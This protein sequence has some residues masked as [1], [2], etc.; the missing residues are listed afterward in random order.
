MRYPDFRLK[1]L[2]WQKNM[3]VEYARLKHEYGAAR[4]KV[5][6][7]EALASIEKGVRQLKSLPVDK[8][9]LAKE[10]NEYK[11]ILN[12]RPNGIRKIWSSIDRKV[13]K[14]RL[15]GAFLGRCA[16]CTLGTIVEFWEVDRM[17]R[18]AK[19]CGM[20]F[21]PKNYW[22]MA[23]DPFALRYGH[24]P[25][26][27]YTRDKM[28]GVPTD[29]DLVYTLLGLL[30]VEQYGHNF[31]VAQNGKAWLKYLPHACTAEK[32][33]LDNLKKGIAAE[34]VAD[35]DNPYCEWIGADIRSDPW[36][37]MAPGWPEMAASMAYRDAVLSHR[38]QGIYGEM[39]FSAAIS[40]AFAVSTPVEALRIGL[41]EIPKEC[42][43]SK[44]IKWALGVSHK[45]KNYKDARKAVDK[46]FEGMSGVHTNNNACLTVFGLTIGGTD[47]TRVISET[48]AMGLD[49]DCTAATAGSI[50]GAIVGKKNIP[51]HWIKRFNNKIH[52]YIIGHKVFAIDDV[53]GR[54]IRQAEFIYSS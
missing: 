9:L 2:D 43:L 10:P 31:T 36:A 39:F 32:V 3:L 37:Y 28:D 45:I 18:F 38:R 21:P 23:Q 34:K 53:I 48:V 7:D 4:V 20:S 16:G 1:A 50:V 25:R 47:F 41:S 6:V 26:I 15:E 19:E 46:R 27:D 29:D 30:V 11:A 35:I 17:E 52:S 13:F 42:T 24:Q 22:T 33:A 54:F 8:K 14:E 49:N 51:V 44:D 5:V 40:A 12:A